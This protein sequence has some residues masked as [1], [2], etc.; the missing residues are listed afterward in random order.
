MQLIQKFTGGCATFISGLFVFIERNDRL[1]RGK[2]SRHHIDTFL[3]FLVV[4]EAFTG[5]CCFQGHSD[6][7]EVGVNTCD[8]NRGDRISADAFP[9]QELRESMCQHLHR[10]LLTGSSA[11][12]PQFSVLS[13]NSPNHR[14]LR[15]LLH[16]CLLL[17][18][19]F[20][21]RTACFLLFGPNDC[22]T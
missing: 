13:P 5:C 4:S 16:C 18:A 21:G 1:L 9:F 14:E 7:W 20:E 8:K 11:F 15:W 12:F 2:C 17:V 19:V 22:L 6:I 3:S 10:Q